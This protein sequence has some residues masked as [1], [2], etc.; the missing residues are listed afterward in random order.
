MNSNRPNKLNN[1]GMTYF[2]SIYFIVV[3][4]STV[5]EK[6]DINKIIFKRINL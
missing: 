4:M 3:T 6:Q 2:D 1:T 5:I